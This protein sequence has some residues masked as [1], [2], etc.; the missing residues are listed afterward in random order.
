MVDTKKSNSTM[1]SL[2]FWTGL[3]PVSYGALRARNNYEDR[4]NPIA[5]TAITTAISVL[6]AYAAPPR[7]SLRAPTNTQ[8]L[9][10]GTPYPSGMR[11]LAF[12]IVTTGALAVN[13]TSQYVGE[14]IA[15]ADQPKNR[16]LR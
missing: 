14:Q 1:G 4:S 13:I 11:L 6:K 10:L 8:L 2:P 5:F 16:E 7:D 3:L 12:G 15:F 9:A